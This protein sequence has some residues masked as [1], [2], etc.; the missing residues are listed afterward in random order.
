M[1]DDICFRAKA[2]WGY[3]TVFME[4]VRDHIRVSGEAIALGRVWV[5]L[6]PGG[7]PGGVVQVDRL[8]RARAD[9]TLLFVAPE[10]MGRG[11]GRALFDKACDL[12]RDLGTEELLIDSDPQAAGF[13][14]AM[15]A[16][17]VG[18]TATG[19][20]GR[21]LPRFSMALARGAL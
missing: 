15:G 1:L 5:A 4:N 3:D 8:D 6:D 2:H 13:Y 7:A 11:F 21:L 12:A 10:Q 18:D 20:R 16:R 9:L 17:H 19:Y 14:A